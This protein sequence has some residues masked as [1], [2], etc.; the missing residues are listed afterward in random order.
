MTTAQKVIK[1]VALVLAAFIII[2][3]ISAILFGL[4]LIGGIFG[5]TNSEDIL[6]TTQERL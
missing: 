6:E 4:S 2:N 5:L 1:Y 3:I